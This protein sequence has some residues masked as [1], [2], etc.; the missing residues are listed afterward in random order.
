MR[1]FEKLLLAVCILMTVASPMVG[2]ESFAAWLS[3]KGEYYRAMTEYQ[4][5]MIETEDPLQKENLRLKANECIYLLGDFRKAAAEIP[6]LP[7]KH[8]LF[9]QNLWLKS[10]AYYEADQT[11]K[12]IQTLNAVY[13]KNHSYWAAYQIYLWSKIQHKEPLTIFKPPGEIPKNYPPYLK[14]EEQIT[15]GATDALAAPEEKTPWL[16]ALSSFVLPGSGQMLL[17]EWADGLSS[18]LVTGGLAALSAISFQSHETAL[19]AG[20]GV[21]ATLFYAGSIYGAY[22][23]AERQNKAAAHTYRM[24][25]E[26]FLFRYNFRF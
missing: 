3:Q 13:E 6:S 11:P 9:E 2:Q 19:G 12:A 7:S 15:D 5:Q 17:G 21:V 4:R 22:A 18:L 24:K 1:R 8:P 16:Y 26:R 20:A 25:A 10:L 23:E 14:I